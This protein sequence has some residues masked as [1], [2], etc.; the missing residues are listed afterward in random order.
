VASGTPPATNVRLG[1]RTRYRPNVRKYAGEKMPVRD[2]QT[3]ANVGATVKP[4][5]L[6]V[7][8]LRDCS[9]RGQVMLDPCAGVGTT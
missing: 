7:D 5:A 3:E 4:V 2:W 9:K 8:A 1:D 6:L